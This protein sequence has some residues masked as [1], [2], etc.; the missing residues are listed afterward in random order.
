MYFFTTTAKDWQNLFE[1]NEIKVIL[2]ES[3][4][5]LVVNKKAQIH[6]FVI[7]PNHIH[8]L[9]TPLDETYD[10]SASFKSFTA[11]MIRK[12]LVN[13][14]KLKLNLYISTQND[15]EYQ[16]WKRRSKSIE[17]QNRI[18]AAQKVEYIH[19]NPL[20][21]KWK[22]VEKPEDYVYSSASYY[23]SDK[24]P[25]YFLTRYEDWI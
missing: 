6:A 10:I 23:L 8:L 25:F 13:H 4:E 24:S 5:W 21:E 9:W 20:Q 11:T 1:D 14:N 19:N 3:M 16:F 17:M 15:R 18:I 22:L 2:I 7:M 12:F